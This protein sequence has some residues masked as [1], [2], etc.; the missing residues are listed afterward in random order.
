MPNGAVSPSTDVRE[1]RPR[2]RIARTR[3]S[4]LHGDF[5]FEL[6]DVTGPRPGFCL[7]TRQAEAQRRDGGYHLLTSPGHDVEQHIR[8][9]LRDVGRQRGYVVSDY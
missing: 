2:A 1:S 4:Y 3:P 5:L 6:I 8:D 9:C 7:A